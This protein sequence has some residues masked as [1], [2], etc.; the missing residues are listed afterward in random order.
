MI[1]AMPRIAIAVNDFE[2]A[3]STFRNHFGKRCF[4]HRNIAGN[5][6]KRDITQSAKAPC[7]TPS[8]IDLKLTL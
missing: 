3:L 2:S 8:I 6:D 5:T 1:T 4:S 7:M